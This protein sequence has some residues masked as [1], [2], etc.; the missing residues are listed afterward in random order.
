MTI[1]DA[2]VEYSIDHKGDVVK[3]TDIVEE[4]Y[5]KYNIQESSILPAD[6]EIS[7]T[8]DNPKVFER[9]ERGLYKCLGDTAEAGFDNPEQIRI[10]EQLE[11]EL[12]RMELKHFPSTFLSIIDKTKNEV[13]ISK[14]LAFLMNP[15][16]TTIK[17][18]Q[19]VL[20][21]ESVG[22]EELADELDAAGYIDDKVTE[23][24]L[25]AGRID[26]FFKF[27]NC[28]IVIEN[29]ID[30][31][32]NGEQTKRYVES[33][34]RLN[35][36]GIQ[37]VYLYLKPKYN[38][39]LPLDNRRFVVVYYEEL[40][41][42]LKQCSVYDFKYKENYVFME[43]FITH[44]EGY[45]MTKSSLEFGKDIEFYMQ[46]KKTLNIIRNNYL[47]Q[48][49]LV[50]DLLLRKL[51]EALPD[52]LMYSASGYIQ[53]YKDHWHN[54]RKNGI[55]YEI[56]YSPEIIGKDISVVFVLHVEREARQY[57]ASLAEI[58]KS[59]EKTVTMDFSDSDSA[60]ES[61]NEIV[62]MTEKAVREYTQKIDNILSGR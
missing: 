53:I 9:V 26:L 4:I 46:N 19:G 42:I 24:S 16:N 49:N 17:I 5:R 1:R 34:E 43:D 29:K 59:I 54:E 57:A 25:D 62:G 14:V 55:H 2:M 8:N 23:I 47:K 10:L 58:C 3:H 33:V 12:A 30:S 27:T 15:L 22:Q 7:L 40:L 48:C 44:M 60:G 51:E 37:T 11:K 28:W 50:K 20:R 6:Y 52:Y 45:I 36:D 56:L 31:Y 61:I 18:L 13:V 38:G 41:E 32:E 35:G 39:S 21:L